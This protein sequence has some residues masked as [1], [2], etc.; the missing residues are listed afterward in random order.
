MQK[1]SKRYTALLLVL[2][3]LLPLCACGEKPTADPGGNGD[4]KPHSAG[5]EIEQTAASDDIFTLNYNS[6][7]SLNPMVAT[8][9]ANQL[10]CYLVYENMIEVDNNYNAIPNVITEWET[11]D[12]GKHWTFK[13]DT[14]RRFHNG[15]QMTAKDVAYSLVKAMNSERFARRLYCVIGCTAN[16]EKSFSVTCSTPN[17]LLP[18]LLA[19]PV[20]KY[21]SY[22]EDYPEGTGPYT[23]AEDYRSLVRFE[24]YKKGVT[25]PLDVIYLKE[26]TGSTEIMS[27]FEDSLIDLVM[28]DPSA[29]TNLGYA[30]VNE[31]RGLNT[32]NLHYIGFNMESKIMGYAGMRYAM[33]FAFDREYIVDQFSGYALAANLPVSPACS[34]YDASYA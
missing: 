8:N 23:Y 18:Q 31:I 28:N 3:M 26:Y 22:G 25:A 15:E 32:C 19:V 24:D 13:V 6:S 4:I 12:N 29:P 10:V 14:S 33:N 1:P 20:I 30:N 2:L 11:K 7:F 9:T 5:K 34:W 17:M 16:D 21:D 27:A